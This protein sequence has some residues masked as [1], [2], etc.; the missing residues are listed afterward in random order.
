MELDAGTC[1]GAVLGIMDNSVDLAEDGG[2][3]RDCAG[4]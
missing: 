2:V 4:K 3:G 1:D